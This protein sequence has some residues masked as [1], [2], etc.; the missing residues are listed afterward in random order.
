MI[1]FICE[2]L[3][4]RTKGKRIN[5]MIEHKNS[6][7]FFFFSLSI[8]LESFTDICHFLFHENIINKSRRDDSMN[9]NDKKKEEI[10]NKVS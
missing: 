6:F 9:E 10:S 5:R 7:S 3:K 1:R 4:R 8:G 2:L